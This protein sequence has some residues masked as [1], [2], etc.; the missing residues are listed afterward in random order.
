M[1]AKL[2]SFPQIS[3]E[4]IN[5]TAQLKGILANIA[6]LEKGW[7]TMGPEEVAAINAA[8][9]ARFKLLAKC[10]PDLK[11]VELSGDLHLSGDLTIDLK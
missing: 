5:A 1:T 2:K 3:R 8:T 9:Q 7:A 10:L 6:L 4:R 11:A